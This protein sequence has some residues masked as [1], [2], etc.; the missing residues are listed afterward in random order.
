MTRCPGRWNGLDF[1]DP[2]GSLVTRNILRF[3]SGRGWEFEGMEGGICPGPQ[4]APG[5][6]THGGITIKDNLSW[7]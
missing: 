2:N 5:A 3:C 6:Q 1:G 7:R 4:R